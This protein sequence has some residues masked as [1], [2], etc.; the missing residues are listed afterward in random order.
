M[1]L[2][3]EQHALRRKLIREGKCNPKQALHYVEQLALDQ[4][5]LNKERGKK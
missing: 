1:T 5:R 2:N 3:R 4:K